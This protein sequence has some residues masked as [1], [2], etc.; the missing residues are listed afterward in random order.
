MAKMNKIVA[1]KIIKVKVISKFGTESESR[2]SF[3]TI[4]T[5]LLIR[6]MGERS[7]IG[8][9]VVSFTLRPLPLR[10]SPLVGPA[11]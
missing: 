8:W 4:L 6:L 1:H 3:Y 7:N 11:E 9:R 2:S 5:N 10:I